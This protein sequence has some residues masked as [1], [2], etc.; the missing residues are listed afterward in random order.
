LIYSFLH[1]RGWS[2]GEYYDI[3]ALGF[4]AAVKQYFTR[5]E[6][7]QYAFSTIA[8]RAMER[9]IAAF[10]RTEAR[11]KEAELRC[12]ANTSM[13]SCDPMEEVEARLFLHDLASIS[14]QT[15][16]ELAVLRL[17]GYTIAEAAQR[18]G[19]TSKRVRKL[20]KELYRIYFQLYPKNI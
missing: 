2:I 5:Q 19:M 16:Y 8:W 14:S 10:Y 9:S 4:L 11:R 17:Q 1:G 13:S 7:K 15:Q 12:L 20:L 3:A 18:R 6:L